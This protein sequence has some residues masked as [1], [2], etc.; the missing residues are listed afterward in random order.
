[1]PDIDIK[2]DGLDEAKEG[3]KRIAD[4]MPGSVY[5]GVVDACKLIQKQAQ[6]VHL[7]GMTLTPR[8]HFL[9]GSV[10]MDVVTNGKQV[11][12]RVGS[13]MAYAAIHEFGSGGLPGGVITI[14]PNKAKYLHF[15]IGGKEVFTKLARV[16]IP[17]REWLLKSFQD[18]LPQIEEI[19]GRKIEL[20]LNSYSTGYFNG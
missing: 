9:Q 2:F 7:A 20:T 15:F 10:K 19:F 4:A 14:R 1:M 12:G 11:V 16:P 3:M 8:S 6:T 5:A 18:V 17:R 13:R